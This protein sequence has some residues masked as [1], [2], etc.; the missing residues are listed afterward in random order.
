MPTSRR[1]CDGV[2]PM[3]RCWP[4]SRRRPMTAATTVFT[5]ITAAKS[6]II[7]TTT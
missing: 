1:I 3:S 6:E 7:P 2:E 5:S 4:N